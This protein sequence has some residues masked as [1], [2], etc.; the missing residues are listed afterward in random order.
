[1]KQLLI[2]GAFVMAVCCCL[3]LNAQTGEQCFESPT[4]PDIANAHSEWTI[5]GNM[6]TI[7]TTFAKTFVDNTYGTNAVGWNNGHTFSNLVGSDNLQLALFD[8]NG[9][10]KLEFKQDY[11]TASSGAPSGYDC[12]GVTGGEGQMILGSAGSIVSATTSLDQNMN[13]F[14]Y[15]LMVNSPAT[16]SSYDPNATYPNWIYEVYYEVT[17]NISAFGTAGFGYPVI[18][19]VHASPSKTGNNTEVVEPTDCPNT[20]ELLLT[21]NCVEDCSEGINLT[22]NSVH[23][24]FT[25]A[26]S[27][28]A[29][30]ED[31]SGLCAGIYSV[32]VMTANNETLTA[33]AEITDASCPGGE[34]CF[35]S[36]TI[37]DIANAHT[38]WTINGAANTITIRT[39]FAKTFVDNTYGTNAIGWSNGHTFSNL[40]GSDNLQ[41][42]LYD[43]NG[44]KKL[45]FKQ[46]YI[47]ASAGAPSGY[48]C[49]GISGGEGQMIAGSAGDVISATSSLDQNMNTFGYVLTTNSPAT[50]SSY[51][52]NATYPNW[53]FDVYYEVTVKLSAFGSAG[54]GY[55]DIVSVHASPSKTGNNTEPVIETECPQTLTL[56]ATGENCTEECSGSI[57]L[58]VNSFNPPFTY[59]WSNNETTKDISNLCPGDY[60]VTVTDA[61][62][63]T[64]SATATVQEANCDGGEQCFASPT[65]PDIAN[66]RSEWSIN[67]NI[68]TIRTTFAKT[69]VDNTYGTNAIGWNNGH[70]FSNLV[71]SDHLQLAL[72]DAN[73]LKKL[74]FKQDY[75]TAS[76]GAPSGYDCLGVS[77]GEGQMILGS[78]GSIL[79]STTSLDQ[80]MNTFGYV[81]TANSP[82][83]DNNYTPNATY[84]NWIYEVW[85]EASIDLNVFG[86]AGF[87]YPRIASVHAS[88][89]KTGNNTEIVNP[90]DCP[91]ECDGSLTV[92]AQVNPDLQC[93]S[94]PPPQN[95][96]CSCEGGGLK[97]ITVMFAGVS[98]S[99]VNVSAS[100][101][102][103]DLIASFT[104]VQFGDVLFV[105][106]TSLPGGKLFSKTFFKVV[107]GKET[108]I[109]TDCKKDIKGRTYDSFKVLGFTDAAGNIC[110]AEA[111]CDQCPCYKYFKQ[112]TL[113]YNGNS[114]ASISVYEDANHTKLIASFSNVQQ[115]NLLTLERSN[116][117][118]PKIIYISV[119][120]GADLVLTSECN[121]IAVGGTYGAFTLVG[122]IDKKGRECSFTNPCDGDGSINLSVSGGVPPYS[123]E[124]SGGESSED[125]SD[126]CSGPFSVT[127]S[128]S[129]GCTATASFNVGT[130]PCE[131]AAI[132]DFVWHD[133]DANGQQDAGEP[134]ISDVMVKL[135]DADTDSLLATDVTDSEGYYLFDGLDLGNYYIIFMHSSAPVGLLPTLSD[136]G[137]DDTD[138]DADISSGKTGIYMLNSGD[139][140]LTVDAGYRCAEVVCEISGETT[141]CPGATATYTGPAGVDSYEWTIVGDGM[142]VGAS[143]QQTVSVTAKNQCGSFTLMLVSS[144]GACSANCQF[145]VSVE[146]LIPPDVS[147][148]SADNEFS[149]EEEIVFPEPVVSDNCGL[150]PEIIIDGDD[151]IPGNCQ[152]EFIIIRTFSVHDACGNG[153]SATFAVSVVDTTP[154]VISGVNPDETFECPE[155]PV[156]S[157]PTASDNCG[158]ATL[159]FMDDITF[160]DCVFTFSVTRTWSATDEC[161]N[162]ST[163]SQTINMN[164]LTAPVITVAADKT[165]ECPAQLEFDQAVAMDECDAQPDLTFTDF[166]IEGDCPN[167]YTIIREFVAVDECGNSSSASQAITVVDETAPVISGVGA[168]ETIECGTLPVFSEPTAEDACGSATLTFEDVLTPGAC[169]NELAVT[170][171]WTATDECGN[172][173]TASQTITI[174]DNTAP[175]ISGVGADETIECPATPAFSEPI[176]TD[177]CGQSSLT[178]EDATVAGNC[179]GQYSVTRTWTATDA[180]GNS[181]TASQTINVNDLT[182][183][184]IVGI[185][186]DETIECPAQ[187]QF[188][189]PT[190]VDA[191]SEA[192]LTFTDHT[193]PGNCPNENIIIREWTAVDE[194]GN[195]SSASQAVTVIDLNAPEISGVGSDETIEC[196][197]TPQFSEP[198]ATDACGNATLTFTDNI[199][200]GN[201]PNEYTI[202]REFVAVDD[203]GNSGS[204]SQA[205]TVVD[206]NAPEISGVGSDE[207]IECPAFPVFSEPTATDACGNVTLTFTD[208]VIPG[209]CPN[210]YTIIR[211]F[212][213]VDECGNSSSASQA[214]T[215]IDE[216][217]PVIS[218]VGADE[219]IECGTLPEFSE[220]VAE[221]ACGN[222][223]LT[224]EDILTP[225]SC[226]NELIVTRVWTTIDECGNSSTASQTITIVDTNAPVISGIGAD[227]TI[228]CPATPEFSEP[229]ANDD[230]GLSTLTFEDAAVPG[231]CAGEYSVTRTWTATD[232][233]GNSSTA[234]QTINVI[235]LTA[236]EITGIGVDEVIECPAVPQFSEPAAADLCSNATLTSSDDTIAGNCANEYIIIRQWTAVDECGNSSSASQAVTVI[237]LNAPLISGIGEDEMIQCPATPEFSEPTATDDCGNATLTFTDNIIPGNCPNSYIIIREFIAVDDCGNSSSAS[238][239][240]TVIDEIAPVFSGVGA[241]ET[242]EC[243]ALPVFSEPTATDA[244]GAVTV[245]FSDELAFGDC[246]YSF[247]IT[248]TWTATD[249]CGN[250]RMVSQTITAVDNT[251]PVFTFVPADDTMACPVPQFG[252]P[253]VEEACSQFTLSFVDDTIFDSAPDYIVFVRSWTAVDGCGNVSETVSQ[254]I[255]TVNTHEPAS[256]INPSC[257][258]TCDGSVTVSGDCFSYLW[259]TGDVSSSLENLCEGTY[260]VTMTDDFGYEILDTVVLVA[261]LSIE[262]E[263]SLTPASCFGA[264]DGSASVTV[265]G[266]TPPYTYEWSNGSVNDNISG[267]TAGTYYVIVTDQHNCTA[268][269]I[270]EILQPEMLVLG[271]MPTPNSCDGGN[272]GSIS[273]TV[274]GGTSPYTFLWSNGETTQ[275][276]SGLQAGIYT[277][278]V[279]DAHLCQSIVSTEV[280]GPAPLVLSLEAT[281]ENCHDSN[282]GAIDLTVSGGTIPYT[283]NWSNG[284]TTEDLSG[285]NEGTYSIT[286]TDFNGCNATGSET[287][288]APSEIGI[289]LSK[290]NVSCRCQGSD[291]CI[292][293]HD[294]LQHGEFISNQYAARGIHIF[295]DANN[296]F[297]TLI[298]FNT[299]STGTPDPDLE[300]DLGNILILP[301]SI[302]DNDNNG[303]ADSPNDWAGGGKQIY[304]FDNARNVQSFVFV[305]NDQQVTGL[306]TAYDAL[307]NVIGTAIIPITAN[308]GFVT[309]NMNVSGV[310]RLEIQ[311]NGSG[312]VGEIIF[313]DQQQQT[314]CCDGT[315]AADVSGGTAPYIYVWSN[316]DVTG[317]IDSL[318][319]GTYTLTVMDAHGCLKDTF[320]TI[321]KDTGCVEPCE[322]INCDDFDACTIDACDNGVC[323]NDAIVCDDNDA[324]TTDE[325]VNG[326]CVFTAINCDD[327]NACTV[328]ACNNG[329]CSN[330][331]V[332][333]DDTDACTTDECVNGQCV[334]TAINCDDNNACTVDACDNGVCSN[335]A[336]DCDDND[337]C[338]TDECVNGQCVFTAINCDDNNACTIDACNNGVCSNDA[339][340]CDDTDAC[341]TDEC[342][343]GQCV[344]TAINCDDNNACT[345]DACDNG[346]CSNDAIV[347]DDDDLCTTEEC[348]LGECLFTPVNCD[349][350][351]ACTTDECFI[352][353]CV[354]TPVTIEV[355]H[356]TTDVSDDCSN[357]QNQLCVLNFAGLP[358]G[359]KLNEQYAAYGIHISGQAYPNTWINQPNISQLII[360]DTYVSGSWDPDLLVDMGNVAIFPEDTIDANN[361]GLVDFP[362]DTRWG[363]NMIFAFDFDRTVLSV[364]IIDHDRA[365]GSITAYDEF[366]NVITTVAIPTVADGGVAVVNVNASGVRKLVID[367][368]DSGGV[369]DIVF[370]CNQVCCDGTAEVSATGGT[371]PY[372][373]S[374]SNGE[375][376][377]SVDSL[378]EGTYYVMVT[379]ANG[380]VAFDTI[381]INPAPQIGFRN[382]Q[383]SFDEV[384]V[385]PMPFDNT[386]NVAFTS[387][388][389]GP[390]EIR[391]LNIL[392]Q[393]IQKESVIAR[394]GKNTSVLNVT[395]MLAEGVY[396]VELLKDGYSEGIKVMKSK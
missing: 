344:F 360:F 253:E 162:T 34:Q 80:N 17:V 320:I 209:D 352:G 145:V 37:P 120:G 359:T 346:V 174:E 235:D 347:C 122:F 386:L 141:L 238:Q 167:E 182:A 317:S 256:G 191:C 1:M 129:L 332:V 79:S 56:S 278:T 114:G 175:V 380:C 180:C 324:C 322:V 36:P 67:G 177:E 384:T 282:D 57:A 59:L 375:T 221:D 298:V 83:T 82:S 261:P 361:N 300:V 84:P 249:L 137:N 373:Y 202:I 376:T 254:R 208:N 272:D 107:G 392:G 306:A 64:A 230:C 362:N 5:N 53:I 234:S 242:I 6:V 8:A 104:N 288:E 51:A 241:D 247:G 188:S 161:G 199:I 186:T 99:N 210:E 378:C 319:E 86:S 363:G 212:V 27:N 69:F 49:L 224:F 19:S 262:I 260:T 338:T 47:T 58:T 172:A 289:T 213:A 349:D 165:I 211:E 207:T 15:V 348:I 258:Y 337:A 246:P 390:A 297:D 294:N 13:T 76:A 106:G 11:I 231:N 72:Y 31:I 307:N 259:S 248:R 330:D 135:Y 75:I 325:C 108:K 350:N 93:D 74:E 147:F 323:S 200:P 387:K 395:D 35:S 197:A 366:N 284:E 183:P 296:H 48:D 50:N 216:T 292:L 4:I 168:N 123:Y 124:W 301:N 60:S 22:V 244:C 276:I 158:A 28:G 394:E 334:F 396:F 291:D 316:G 43:A 121:E 117:N 195:S 89:S 239:A 160:A 255:T 250:S 222:A 189:E 88:P 381:T 102:Q 302:A 269:E 116:K 391:L 100:S 23:S 70:T 157:N 196:P 266:G 339:I 228:E 115:G 268:T 233:C 283:Y 358:H 308:G 371:A 156:F 164:D 243:P 327:N 155:I 194:C 78:A 144:V 179:S 153:S 237:D 277:V 21:G 368:M 146:D 138:S 367:D 92:S 32:T 313:C 206:L 290:S 312:G 326:Q 143:D 149:C 236:P 181:S 341:T 353:Q 263:S 119:N 185:G 127:V 370:D 280:L 2:I 285:L 87:G 39:T 275:N 26:W 293:S 62:G 136:V 118:L 85:Y 257:S 218:G 220:P 351:N 273:L 335:D 193:I 12:L 16:N 204:A 187:P 333:C 223:T 61:N 315:A 383:N 42:A 303:L 96:N 203:C 105:D 134:S 265:S 311:Y 81:L 66:A 264:S 126:L 328:D 68:L 24:P 33:S 112:L 166:T 270:V 198:V 40:V 148:P 151:T 287:V 304:V 321:G 52:P 20:L 132:G 364:K 240:I 91:V 29:A 205:I 94:V 3:R 25:Y 229:T 139:T 18:A 77:G 342:V 393:T 336:I 73:G 217:T 226:E 159:T 382:M 343:N 225:G 97:T 379:D 46:D 374:W 385:F 133:L 44:L 354:N 232:A 54:F 355:T 201:C 95:C 55:P 113:M 299:Y 310:R 103:Q 154:P 331:A 163:A 152:N 215:V 245:T 38:S 329:V 214:I 171:V 388:N 14:G 98:G 173:S 30:T 128:D 271:A 150:T 365:G 109:Y 41:L 274:Y 377:S 281:D 309:V 7:R 219:T 131:L 45:E 71:G 372:S 101:G 140:I 318:C 305:D 192:T 125:L 345:I 65:I 295:G 184:E 178:F 130:A 111:N 227:E 369:T 357:L 63:N 340:V 169:E 286:V 356:E 142:I 389:E 10:K 110:D 267:L 314:V 190:A 252:E 170:R 90:E 176:A 279:T 251:A 9:V